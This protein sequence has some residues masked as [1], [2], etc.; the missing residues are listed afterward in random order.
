MSLHAELIPP[1]THALHAFG[2][3]LRKAQAHAEER[4]IDPAALLGARLYPDMYPLARQVQIACDMV[5]RGAARL[6]G[7][8]PQ[9]FADTETSF[10]E[11]RGRI[12]RVI[13]A[14][15]MFK[16]ADFTG[17]EARTITFKAG[18]SDFSFTGADYLRIWVLP[19]YYFHMTTA[20]AILRHSGVELGKRDFLGG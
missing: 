5:N 6:A 18:S 9:T 13:A 8:D 19:N 11:L 1:V 7:Q 3:F 2:A 10:V 4:K 16:E 15:G 17:A 14:I 12:D 20:Y